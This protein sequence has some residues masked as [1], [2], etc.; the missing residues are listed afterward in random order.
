M[1]FR[2]VL[3][4]VLAAFVLAI[5]LGGT[6]QADLTWSNSSGN[7]TWDAT[8]LNWGSAA[9]TAGNNAVF[10]PMAPGTIT[11]S[12][13]QSVGNLTF[14]TAGYTIGG[15][16]LAMTGG[17][18]IFGSQNAMIN[19][20]ITSTGIIVLDKTY[21]GKATL[22]GT[23]NVN[24]FQVNGGTAEIGGILNTVGGY[25]YVGNGDANNGGDGANSNANTLIIDP[26][27]Q[28]SITG[29]LGDSFVI[30]RDNSNKGTVIQNG[31][32]LNFN[33][34]NTQSILVSAGAS[35][36][37]YNM[38][39]GTLN[40]NSNGLG[41]GNYGGTGTFNLSAGL[42]QTTIFTIGLQSGFGAFNQSG[43][44]I[45]AS[46]YFTTC[47][48]GGGGTAIY[49]MSGG[50]LHR[51]ARLHPRRRYQPDLFLLADRRAGERRQ[52]RPDQFRPQFERQGSVCHHRRDLHGHGR[53][54]F[55][56][57]GAK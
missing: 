36:G 14:N 41:V 49:R 47:P 9:W 45:T 57:G 20:N 48:S 3:A 8:S 33:P 22:G 37:I 54:R 51:V 42:V 55:T 25:T 43:G 15:G 2:S 23:I 30:G 28:V 11:V 17:A 35:T 38:N 52:Y 13:S 27:A 26:G 5:S 12:G 6:A 53:S 39:G 50:A 34:S 16:T 10:G 4:A 40:V 44:T 29:S 21:T 24:G 31:G 56:I 18:G 7:W 19:S 46:S 1:K 32:L